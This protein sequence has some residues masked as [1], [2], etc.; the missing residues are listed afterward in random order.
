MAT[1][2]KPPKHLSR[3]SKRLWRE[4]NQDFELETWFLVTLQLSLEELD[5]LDRAN[6]ILR[7]EGL[8]IVTPS[9]IKRRP[10]ASW[11]VELRSTGTTEVVFRHERFGGSGK[12]RDV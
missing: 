3:R 7:E 4:I 9:G 8:Y 12:R 1:P 10:P 11:L 5:A 6:E 2:N